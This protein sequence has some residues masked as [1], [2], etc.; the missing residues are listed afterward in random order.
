MWREQWQGLQ[1]RGANLPWSVVAPLALAVVSGALAYWAA[2]SYLDRA[3]RDVALRYADAHAVRPVIVAARHVAAGTPLD[4]AQ[5]A[6]RTVPVR[7][8]PRSAFGPEAAASL[9]GRRAARDLEPGEALTPAA[10]V[11]SHADALASRFVPGERALTIAVDDTNSHASLVRPGDRVD[12]LWVTDAAS[13]GAG[14]VAR[15]LLQAVQVLATGKTL[16]E[17]HRSGVADPSGDAGVREYTTL[18]LRVEPQDAARIA[19]AERAGELLI[20]LRATDDVRIDATASMTVASMLG[21]VAPAAV[22]DT[23]PRQR[24]VGWVGGR[25]G[26]AV[27][28][29][30]AVGAVSAQVRP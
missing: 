4:A 5:L 2:Q 24:I 27:A 15:P 28:H 6:Q 22:R 8:V 7:Y 25:G 26:S 3:E 23:S 14:L 30:W 13:E 17:L 21:D 9:H 16:R 10:V 18:T 20:T 12:L 11:D 29:A 19:L 1:A